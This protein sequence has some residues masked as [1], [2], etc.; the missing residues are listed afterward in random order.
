MDR[1]EICYDVFIRGELVDLIVLTEEIAGKTSWYNWFND[2]D[3]TVNMQ[4]HYFPN[5]KRDQE[6]YFINDISNDKSKLQLGIFHKEDQLL[7][8]IIALTDINFINR[9]CAIAGLIGEKKYRSIIYYLEANRL[10]IRHAVHSL[11]MHKI[12]GGSISREIALYY[13]RM[14]GFKIEGI[15][16]QDVYKDGKYKD[17][18]MF[19]RIFEFGSKSESITF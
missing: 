18:Y 16:K 5:T 13:E 15:L 19:A 2:E 10:L 14:L 6:R 17:A 9:K 4:K 12:S 8:G 7:I 3:N 1:P 11:N